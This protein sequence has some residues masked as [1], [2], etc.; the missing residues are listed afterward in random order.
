MHLDLRN[1]GNAVT[2]K[3]LVALGQTCPLLKTLILTKCVSLSFSALIALANGCLKLEMLHLEGMLE[4]GHWVG[5][6]IDNNRLSIHFTKQGAA[7][8]MTWPFCA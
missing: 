8:W 1:G 5:A 3:V 4:C 2:D 7:R 6:H